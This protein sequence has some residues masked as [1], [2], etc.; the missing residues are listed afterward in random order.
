MNKAIKE[1]VEYLSQIE[2]GENAENL[3]RGNSHESKIRRQNLYIYLNF[4]QNL[5]T[6]V[7]LVGEAPGHR[8]C[9][10]TG[11]PFTSEKILMKDNCFGIFG[12]DKGYAYINSSNKLQ[13]EVSAAIV[14][15]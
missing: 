13:T 9:K 2:A 11:I 10:L 12:E 5:P 7:L 8:G 14:W 4:M 1:F 15:N 6:S 3:Y